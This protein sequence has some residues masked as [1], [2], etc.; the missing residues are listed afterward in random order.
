MILDLWPPVLEQNKCVLFQAIQI[1]KSVV[2]HYRA[3][4]KQYKDDVNE[5]EREAVMC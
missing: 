4:G 2:I 5:E 3:I 1:T